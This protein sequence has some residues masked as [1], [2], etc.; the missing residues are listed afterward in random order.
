MFYKI[1]NEMYTVLISTIV[2]TIGLCLLCPEAESNCWPLVFQTEANHLTFPHFT[3]FI[4][5]YRSYLRGSKTLRAVN[6]EDFFCEY[7]TVLRQFLN[8]SSGVTIIWL[9]INLGALIESVSPQADGYIRY[10]VRLFILWSRSNEYWL[11][12]L[13]FT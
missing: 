9:F 3:L 6:N 4:F 7:E 12:T 1:C 8:Y 11:L 2:N 13:I 5:I 10:L